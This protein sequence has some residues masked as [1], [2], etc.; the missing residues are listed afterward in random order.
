[1]TKFIPPD[2]DAEAIKT[3]IHQAMGFGEP[4]RTDDKAWFYFP[5]NRASTPSDAAADQDDIPFDVTIPVATTDSHARVQVPCA[6]EYFDATGLSITAGEVTPSKIVITL[7]DDEWQQVKNFSF[8]VAGGDKYVRS[9]IEPP[10]ALGSI[11]V[12][13]AHCTAQDET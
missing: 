2:F 6:V 10:V 9:R 5:K 12:W 8:V 7:L 11:D 1:V 13:T 3:G 4:T